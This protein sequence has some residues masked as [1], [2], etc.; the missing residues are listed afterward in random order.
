MFSLH[1]AFLPG[2]QKFCSKF[3][4][5]L[6]MM[7]DPWMNFIDLKSDNGK[8]CDNLCNIRVTGTN[9]STVQSILSAWEQLCR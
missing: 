1:S 9:D 8:I 2:W 4:F 7:T 5:K 6:I 3:C